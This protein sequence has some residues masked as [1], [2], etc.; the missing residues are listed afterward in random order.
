MIKIV[1]D[2]VKNAIVWSE[3]ITLPMAWHALCFGIGT[4]PMGLEI[5]QSGEIIKQYS[6]FHLEEN[7][8]NK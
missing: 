3:L 6:D 8:M 1:L 5:G 4:T 7:I 2:P